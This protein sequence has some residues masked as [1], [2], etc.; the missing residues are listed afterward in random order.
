MK[1]VLGA[2]AATLLGMNLLLAQSSNPGST[3]TSPNNVDSQLTKAIPGSDEERG[4]TN[5]P[6][7]ARPAGI[8]YGVSHDGLILFSPLAPKSYGMGEKYLTSNFYPPAAHLPSTEN[9]EDQR[10]FGGLKLFGIEF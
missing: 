8:A 2:V 7:Q 4:V 9:H 3:F 5:N 10:E 6:H 1:R